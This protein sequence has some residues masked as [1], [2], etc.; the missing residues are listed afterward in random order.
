MLI[1][2]KL[3]MYNFNFNFYVH[4]IIYSALLIFLEQY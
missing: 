3:K 1:A 2:V 4:K